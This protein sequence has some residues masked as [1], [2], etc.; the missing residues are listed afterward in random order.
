MTEKHLIH[1]QRSKKSRKHYKGSYKSGPG[2]WT[3]FLP[4][5]LSSSHPGMSVVSPLFEQC[6]K[7]SLRSAVLSID[8]SGVGALCKWEVIQESIPFSFSVH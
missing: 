5:M 4:L 1:M 2:S 8:Q 7:V 6:F 3:S